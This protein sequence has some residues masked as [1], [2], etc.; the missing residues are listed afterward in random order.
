MSNKGFFGLD[1][2][3]YDRLQE[4]IEQRIEDANREYGYGG[5]QVNMDTAADKWSFC[6]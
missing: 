4:D 6:Q 1:D 3:E 5:R 2:D